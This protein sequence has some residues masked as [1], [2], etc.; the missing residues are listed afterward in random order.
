MKVA[1]FRVVVFTK[2]LFEW[3]WQRPHKGGLVS[4]VRVCKKAWGSCLHCFISLQNDV[5]TFGIVGTRS[6]MINVEVSVAVWAFRK[7]NQINKPMLRL[8]LLYPMLRPMILKAKYT[9]CNQQFAPE[10]RPSLKRRRV[11]QP[12][13]S[14]CELFVLR[15]GIVHQVW[16]VNL[17]NIP[18][19]SC[20]LT[21]HSIYPHGP[22]NT[23][24]RIFTSYMYAM[25]IH[26]I[27]FTGS[28]YM[29]AN[30]YIHMPKPYKQHNIYVAWTTDHMTA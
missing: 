23:Y 5:P 14:S 21:G 2:N 18:L 1:C 20:F 9:F 27:Y 15:E 3:V 10:N 13:T 29:H 22:R 11:F 4:L 19:A 7:P 25:Y 8:R 30:A 16:Q 24:P 12:S 6:M 28:F 17:S 26:V